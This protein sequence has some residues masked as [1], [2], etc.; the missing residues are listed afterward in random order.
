[1]IHQSHTLAALSSWKE[2]P[3][4]IG[5]GQEAGWVPE[6]AWTMWRR[7]KSLF[8]SNNQTPEIQL[9]ACHLTTQLTIFIT[10]F[11]TLLNIL[12]SVS[13][14]KHISSY[15]MALDVKS[16]LFLWCVCVCV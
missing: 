12:M 4:T 2:A 10:H 15:T 11:S 16:N 7:G 5:Q 3:S 1:V 9:T 13:N 8:L 6:P 14:I